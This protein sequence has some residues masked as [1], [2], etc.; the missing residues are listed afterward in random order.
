MTAVEMMTMTMIESDG[1]RLHV[2]YNCLLGR[3]PRPDPGSLVL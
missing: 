3:P 1:R 2:A